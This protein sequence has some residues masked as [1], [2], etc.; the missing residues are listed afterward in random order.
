MAQK[1]SGGGKSTAARKEK[2]KVTNK[3]KKSG[4][5]TAG[6]VRETRRE[7][8]GALVAPYIIGL[9]ALLLGIFIYAQPY[10]GV[11]GG[12]IG[13][14]FKGVFSI[15]AFFIP[16]VLLV[17]ALR[18]R[19]DIE[20]GLRALRT[21]FGIL[22]II[23]L[24]MLLHLWTG[25]KHVLEAAVHYADGKLLVGGGVVG[26]V[27]GELLYK[28]IRVG[29]PII[30]VIG[31][32]VLIPLFVGISPRSV[33]AFVTDK[34][35]EAKERREI[36]AEENRLLR[37]DRRAQREAER[38]ERYAREA[39]ARP[40]RQIAL[41]EEPVRPRRNR[42]DKYVADVPMPD[43]DK[44]EDVAP[45]V[46]QSLFG[47]EPEEE[48]EEDALDGRLSEKIDAFDESDEVVPE[49]E[50]AVAENPTP[51]LK[52]IFTEPAAGA[53]IDKLCE[54]AA[55]EDAS[56]ETEFEVVREPV[57]EKK[58]T[59]KPAP[60]K[61][62]E[63]KY[64]FPPIDL[65]I[66]DTSKKDPGVKEEL[67][68]NAAKLVETLASFNVKA[69]VVAISRGPTITRYELEPELGTRVRNITNLIDDISLAFA[70]SG[71]RV[72]PVPGKSA[73]G[74]EVPNKS[75]SVVRLRTLISDSRFKNSSSKLTVGL[76]EDVA[77]DAM[78]TDIAKMPHMLIAGTTGSGKS[79]CINC[80][81]ISLLYKSTPDEVKFILIDP[82]K[83][84]F[85]VYNS[86]PH[87]LVPVVSDPKKAAGALSW[88]VSEMER[89]FGLIERMGVRDLEHYNAAAKLQPGCEILPQIVIVIDELADLMMTAR[90]SV[91]AS[92][93]R[94]AQKARAAGMHLV[95][96][97]QRPSVDVITGLIK[98]NVPSRIAFTV[99]SQVDSRTV[100]DR[101]GAERLI[102]RG[103]M[104][105]N[106]VGAPKP[107]RVQGAFISDAEIDAV[108]EFIKNSGVSAGYSDEVIAQIDREAEQCAPQKKRAGG[109][110]DSPSEGGGDEDA[111][112]TKA[113]EIAVDARK[114]STSLL[115]RKM[116]VGYGRA[117]KI[118]DMMESRGYIS[119]QDGQKPREVLITREQFLEMSVRGDDE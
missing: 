57:Q 64:K 3:K 47:R 107:M 74:V 34:A 33:V 31:L 73:V 99:V 100:I 108:V 116:S 87:L 96:G 22:I 72:E 94:I 23:L 29:M 95:I 66:E 21:V 111:L 35:G 32:I 12:A 109:D 38:A 51:D 8:A 75:S 10:S 46:D 93:C 113:L 43:G 19:S 7:S 67:K 39:E 5:R 101:A 91:E 16:P 81:L 105:Y 13:A 89:R 63:P 37:E 112:F 82:K 42:S 80:M 83:V 115:Q 58:P 88:A 28:G 45:E 49:K 102:G 90:D 4:G 76:G 61:P 114:I 40:G 52:K 92:I 86:L 50:P 9:F 59:L 36:E 78:Y 26:G 65:L 98:S 77:G 41:D 20:E 30:A 18:V 71:V 27:L 14:F 1:K 6:E 70:S 55:G 15:G 79:V 68:E 119:A 53:D 54:D 103:D 25:G 48:E 97:T 110:D 44:Y 106:P 84:E 24:S 11:V 69:N 85:N 117:A 62:T 104:L 60:E 118:I 56:A 17:L 2:F